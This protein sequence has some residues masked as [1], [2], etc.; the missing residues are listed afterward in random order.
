M[1][2]KH[3]TGGRGLVNAYPFGPKRPSG[4]APQHPLTSTT[5]L[6]T[7][8]LTPPPAHTGRTA[9]LGHPRESIARP[10]MAMRV[11]GQR[12]L[13]AMRVAGEPPC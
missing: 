3:G 8:H 6:L 9:V 7:G 5:P 13:V 2:R 11:R 4:S 1:T 12:S 10:P